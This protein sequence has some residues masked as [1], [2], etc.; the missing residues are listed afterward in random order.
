[1]WLCYLICAVPIVGGFVAWRKSDKVTLAEWIVPSVACVMTAFIWH[2]C[3]VWGS[4]TDQETWSGYVN[5]AVRY[6]QWVEKY[7]HAVYETRLVPE[8]D[9]E[10]GTV[11]MR[12]KSVFSHHEDRFRTHGE[13]CKASDTLGQEY[14]ISR[15]MFDEYA[16]HFEP[17]SQPGNKRGFHQGDPKIYV[18]RGDKALYPTTIIKEWTNNVKSA[19]SLFKYAEIPEGTKVFEYPFTSGWS[20]S[21]RLLG[22]AAEKVAINDWDR[23][24]ARLGPTKKVNLIACGFPVQGDGD[25]CMAKYQE[26]AW[27]GGKKNDL[28][29]CFGGSPEQPSWVKVFGWTERDACKRNLEDIVLKEGFLPATLTSIEKEVSDN[30]EI[31]DW[32]AMDYLGV[33]PSG[34]AYFTLVMIL[35][36]TQGVMWAIALRNDVDKKGA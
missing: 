15:A 34:W 3:I 23:L 16:S 1:M 22:R 35:V 4:S 31:R 26:A 30:Y 25:F 28:V 36:V 21:K 32:S 19:P 7:Q 6:P 14:E 29:I 10:S 2:L 5:R 17:Q 20:D 33:E 13:T 8:F 11:N 24:N 12:L 27:L 18:C 9:F